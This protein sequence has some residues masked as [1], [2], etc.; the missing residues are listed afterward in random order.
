MPICRFNAVLDFFG[1]K[2]FYSMRDNPG[3]GYNLVRAKFVFVQF[4]I[5][6]ILTYS[7]FYDIFNRGGNR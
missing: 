2:Q 1:I 6:N 7:V 5:Q 3:N 4:Q